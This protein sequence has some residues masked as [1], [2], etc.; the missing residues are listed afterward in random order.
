MYFHN[1][2]DM[3][4]TERKIGAMPE[5]EIRD[6]LSGLSDERLRDILPN[7]YFPVYLNLLSIFCRELSG[8]E[9]RQIAAQCTRT[10]IW[11]N[12]VLDRWIDALPEAVLV[13]NRPVKRLKGLSHSVM[14][15]L[16]REHGGLIVCSFRLGHYGLLP[17]EIALGGFPVYWPIKDA[18]FPALESAFLGLCSRLKRLSSLEKDINGVHLQNAALMHILPVGGR[19]TSLQLARALRSGHIVMMQADGNSGV[20]RPGGGT[21]RRIIDF[22]GLR[23]SV[24]TGTAQLAWNTGAP[25]LPAVA[26]M[27]GM[28]SGE[29]VFGEPIFPPTTRRDEYRDGFV[30]RS[31]Q[32]VYDFLGGLARRYP[33]QWPG[34]GAVHSWRRDRQCRETRKAPGTLEETRFKLERDLRSGRR[35][36]VNEGDGVTS[37]LSES[38]WIFVDMQSL[39]TFNGPRWADAV[40]H[41]LHEQGI[42]SSFIENEI[43]RSEIRKDSTVGSNILALLTEL[44]NR[45][46]ITDRDGV[47]TGGSAGAG[48]Q[49]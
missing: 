43:G 20:R 24:K 11:S 15:S 23:I 28:D 17:L 38:G 3:V 29:V 46:L 6:W 26:L 10:A 21:S 47:S 45:G 18:I 25:I 42:T 12:R 16:V 13:G 19:D 7:R 5:E 48:A 35:F 1:M 49:A 31:M 40:L 27:D 39:Q 9:I 8:E 22:M 44:K 34:V 30:Q 37:F 2:T 14:E 36:V 33:D 4:L 41:R 32:E